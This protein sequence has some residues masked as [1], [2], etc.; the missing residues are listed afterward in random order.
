MKISLPYGNSMEA[1]I[2]EGHV[3]WHEEWAHTVS[4]IGE[5]DLGGIVGK[6][7]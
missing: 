4:N 6:K 7:Q 2:S 5:K 1:N 3:I